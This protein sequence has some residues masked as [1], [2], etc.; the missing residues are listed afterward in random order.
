ML[1][2]WPL[3]LLSGDFLSA[4]E[5]REDGLLA[6]LYYSSLHGAPS[7]LH[8]AFA[9]S[10]EADLHPLHPKLCSSP[11]YPYPSSS[12]LFT[13]LRNVV[14]WF[15]VA[16]TCSSVHRSDGSRSIYPGVSN[17]HQENQSC[18]TDLNG[19]GGTR[20]T[21]L[22]ATKD[23]MQPQEKGTTT[24]RKRPLSSFPPTGTWIFLKSKNKESRPQQ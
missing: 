21:L 9:Y 17:L 22:S 4:L 15:I 18:R 23:E 19:A 11:Y 7:N 5:S 16:N 2:S 20:Q 10:E 24:L 8:G 1:P 3:D 13:C 6:S 12:S 14:T